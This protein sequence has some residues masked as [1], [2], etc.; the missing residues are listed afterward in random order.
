MSN[1]SAPPTSP[2]FV[3]NATG[4]VRELSA[5][6]ALAFNSG[7]INIGLTIVFMFLYAPSFHPGGSMVLATV[8]GT[9]LAI[10]MA[11]ANAMLASIYPRSGGEY[12]YNSRV[13]SPAVGFATN[14]N[15]TIWLLFYVGASGVLF[16][17]YG[18][19]E[20]LRF[21][22]IRWNA[23][24][25]ITTASWAVTPTGEFVVGSLVVAAVI[26][27]LAVSTNHMARIQG[28]YFVAGIIGAALAII[29][30]IAS[31]RQSYA[32][33]FNGY[34]GQLAGEKATLS[35]LVAEAKDKGYTTDSF[36]LPATLLVFFW[37]ASFLFW[38]NCS[39]Y[40]GGEVQYAKRSQ[41][42]GSFGAVILCGLF[43]SLAAYAVN[44]A[45]GD[46]QLGAITYLN[47]VQAGLGFAPSYAELAA[48]ATSSSLLGLILLLACA[49]WPILFG[50]LMTGAC[51][52][53][54]LA[55]SMDRLAPEVL[56]RVSPK[57]HTPLPALVVCG[58]I[59]ELSVIL[60]A[61]IP[62]FAF[63]VGIVGAFLT[64]M[65]T[66]LSAT[67]LPFRR[68]EMFE[69]SSVNWRIG[70]FPVMTLVG[71][72]ALLGLLCVEISILSDPYSGVSLFPSTDA[73]AGAGIPFAM[74]WVNLG[75][76]ALGFVVYFV[77]KWI[78]KAQGIDIGLAFKEIPPE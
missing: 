34:F 61:F 44:V 36:S 65:T 71:A 30:L 41:I 78:R 68:P 21:V 12:V 73:G 76:F 75:I 3:R 39:T 32:T 77:T 11:F 74:L 16:A 53:S 33:A 47:A 48:L 66:A 25:F 59:G 28:W 27:G 6:H 29:V 15:I 19:A 37:P 26:I 60:Y 62:A 45:L 23:P 42:I 51:T 55:W 38:G 57:F 18:L 20:I 1:Q 31:D 13:L 4:L 50:S 10:P 56:S 24:A 67:L 7:F 35:A 17:Q 8:L 14:F 2:L 46:D 64:F 9:L 69:R 52:R 43:I 49:C 22:G 5:F 58:I 40:F 54:F 70:G 63:A 72:L